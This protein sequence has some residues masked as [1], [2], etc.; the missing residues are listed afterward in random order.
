[1]ELIEI[2]LADNNKKFH[3]RLLKSFSKYFLLLSIVSICISILNGLSKSLM[4]TY[5]ICLII[6][7]IYCFIINITILYG[8]VINPDIR[9]ILIK[10]LHFNK[11]SGNLLFPIDD[12]EISMRRNYSFRYEVWTIYFFRGRKLIF[13][14][15]GLNG[16]N[17]ELFKRVLSKTKD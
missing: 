6:S 10:T 8:V 16:W 13:K 12:L 3:V 2:Y 15:N 1:M 11:V 7:F 5:I 9:T 17:K 4:I 14:Q